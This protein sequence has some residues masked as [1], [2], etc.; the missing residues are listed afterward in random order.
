LGHGDRD[1]ASGG[2][3]GPFPSV[4]TLPGGEQPS[5][6]RLWAGPLY[7][8]RLKTQSATGDEGTAPWSL[9]PTQAVPGAR[10]RGSPT[11]RLWPTVDQ[12]HGLLHDTNTGR[13]AE[14][15][16]WTFFG[17]D[18]VTV[19]AM[20]NQSTSFARGLTRC[21]LIVPVRCA[22]YI[23]PSPNIEPGGGHAAIT[24]RRSGR[25]GAAR[26]LPRG[27]RLVT[28]TSATLSWTEQ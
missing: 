4:G 22:S 1:R 17:R 27:R 12:G 8:Y 2:N 6:I 10:G 25:G 18:V 9:P 14:A 26:N 23:A 5:R 15:T 21:A 19:V 11:C 7:Q 13:Y 28:A 20:L 16:S 3:V 24:K